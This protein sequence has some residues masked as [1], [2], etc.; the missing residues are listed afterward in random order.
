MKLLC[1]NTEKFNGADHILTKI[2]REF[3]TIVE[4][5]IQEQ[6]KVEL[7]GATDA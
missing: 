5:F 6:S 3:V 2:A 4:N 1:E 7:R